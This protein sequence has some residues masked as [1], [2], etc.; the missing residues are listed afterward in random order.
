MNKFTYQIISAGLAL[1]EDNVSDIENEVDEM[2]KL[3]DPLTIIKANIN[4][5]HEQLAA[6]LLKTVIILRTFDDKEYP[7][8]SVKEAEE[9]ISKYL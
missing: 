2:D 1:L 4:D 3:V 6:D 8:N 7:F 9:F 5:L